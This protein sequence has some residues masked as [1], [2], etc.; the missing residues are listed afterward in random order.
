MV[1]R[2]LKKNMKRSYDEH[3][4][5]LIMPFRYFSIIEV[6]IIMGSSITASE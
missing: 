2:Q 5:D 1:F 6:L 4:L 3:Y